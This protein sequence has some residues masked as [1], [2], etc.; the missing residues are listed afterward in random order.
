MVKKIFLITL[1]LICS[2]HLL[3]GRHQFILNSAQ[4]GNTKIQ[5][6]PGDI[7]TESIGEYTRFVSPNSGKTTKQGMLS[8][9]FSF[10]S[11]AEVL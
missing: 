6:A 4:N 11:S 9:C 7:Q 8:G 5:F 1:T 10:L 3:V 2:N